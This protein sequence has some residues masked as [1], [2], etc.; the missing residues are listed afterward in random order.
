MLVKRDKSSKNYAILDPQREVELSIGHESWII[1]I[2]FAFAIGSVKSRRISLKYT[3][4]QEKHGIND[5]H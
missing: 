5:R 3:K 2:S 1:L 4:S